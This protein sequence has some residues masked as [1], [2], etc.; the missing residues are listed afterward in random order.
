MI[1]RNCM[2][3]DSWLAAEAAPKGFA[4]L[5]RKACLRRLQRTRLTR[6]S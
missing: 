3:A 6:S 5:N 4:A 2:F 1:A